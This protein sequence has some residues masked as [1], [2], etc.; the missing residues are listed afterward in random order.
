ML[1]LHWMVCY[2]STY[3]VLLP[4]SVGHVHGG[5]LT[6][7]PCQSGWDCCCPGKLRQSQ[8][9][10]YFHLKLVKFQEVLVVFFPKTCFC[11]CFRH[12]CSKNNYKPDHWKIIKT[13]RRVIALSLSPPQH[14][15][16]GRWHHRSKEKLF[17]QMCEWYRGFFSSLTL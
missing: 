1:Y 16:L 15:V 8:L 13:T 4:D 14:F 3:S 12:M 6:L 10:E 11:I 2:T 7:K 17:L 9:L 5:T